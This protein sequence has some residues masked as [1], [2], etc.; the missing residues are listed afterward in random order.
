[1]NTNIAK[2]SGHFISTTSMVKF[3]YFFNKI[4]LCQNSDFES[5]L[6]VKENVKFTLFRLYF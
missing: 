6:A 2:Q 1:M 4:E 5:K 3:R